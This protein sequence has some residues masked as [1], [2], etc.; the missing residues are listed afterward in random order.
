MPNNLTNRVKSQKIIFVQPPTGFIEPSDIVVIPA[1][2]KQTM[3]EYL[4]AEYNIS[5]EILYNDLQG[6]IR[7]RS[8]HQSAYTEFHRGVTYQNR[9]DSAKDQKEKQSQYE[10]AI[11]HYTEALKLKPDLLGA[12]YN[13]GV[14][15][16]IKGDIDQAIEDLNKAVELNPEDANIYRNRGCLLRY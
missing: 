12:Y 9:G 10:K 11:G 13:R 7:N 14:V 3:L 4:R 2:L 6:F 16:S 1:D 5:A 15:H 8:I